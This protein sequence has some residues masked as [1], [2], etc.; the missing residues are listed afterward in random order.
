MFIGHISSGGES[1]DLCSAGGD[2]GPNGQR[3]CP[4]QTSKTWNESLNCSFALSR[5]REYEVG[6]K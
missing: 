5:I 2:S 1:T 3:L 6:M 4:S